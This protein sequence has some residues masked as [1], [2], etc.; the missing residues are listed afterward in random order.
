[1]SQGWLLDTNILSDLVRNPAGR[2][3]EHIRQRGEANVR[4][5]VIVAAELRFG[6]A[7]KGSARLATQLEAILAVIQILP[8]TP[9]AD[10][11]YGEIR[12]KLESVGTPIGGNDMLIAAHALAGDDILVTNN[13]R[14][15]SRVEGLSIENWL[16]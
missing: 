12:A 9:P 15:F 3:A 11:L 10:R 1:M 14:E 6:A 2:V 5:S 4:T 8:L 13:D 7:K 16:R